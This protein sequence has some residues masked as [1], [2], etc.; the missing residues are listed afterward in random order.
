[1]FGLSFGEIV[2]LLLL[3]IVVIGPR[4]LP[5]MLRTAGR[6]VTKLRRMAFDMRAQSGIDDIL[7][8]EGLDND[9]RQLR[10]ILRRGNVLDALA[11]DVDAEIA[12]KRREEPTRASGTISHDDEL[13]DDDAEYPL[14]GAD[15]YG[16][17]AEDRDPYAQGEVIEAAGAEL[18]A[19]GKAEGEAEAGEQAQAERDD[20]R[21]G[22]AVVTEAVSSKK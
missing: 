19:Q 14:A 8:D 5:S 2:V 15:A 18:D 3:A 20:T 21:G 7:R 9:L 10:A 1:V 22:A 17:H 13:M 12:R 4:Q 16:A 11:I 6:W